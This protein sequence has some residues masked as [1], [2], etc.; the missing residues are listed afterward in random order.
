MAARFCPKSDYPTRNHVQE[1]YPSSR[2][3]EVEEGWMVFDYWDEYKYWL[4]QKG[5]E[6]DKKWNQSAISS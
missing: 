2:V 6:E 3:V 4:N 5:N 1:E